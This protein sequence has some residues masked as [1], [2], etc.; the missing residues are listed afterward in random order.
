MMITFFVAVMTFDVKRIKAGRRD[1]LPFCLAPQPK[2]GEVP[3]DEPHP[4][5]SNRI[6]K[7]W[8]KFLMLPAS[9]L[10]VLLMS[11]AVLALGIYGTTKVTER[12]VIMSY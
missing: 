6:M 5:T 10:F 9:K 11:L 12:S 1:C 2:E 8:A 4:Q 3:W 7:N